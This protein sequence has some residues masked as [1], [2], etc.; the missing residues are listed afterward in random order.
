MISIFLGVYLF[1]GISLVAFSP[2]GKRIV[3]EVDKARGTEFTNSIMGR[4]QPSEQK[5]LLF[6][7]TLT[8]GFVLLWCVFIWSIL[9]EHQATQNPS[10]TEELLKKG[11]RFHLMGGYGTLSCKDCDFSQEITSFTHGSSNSKSG[12]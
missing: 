3:E 9:K 10:G 12:F 5:V 2:A 4:E 1:I 6:R 7:I 11:M 8:L